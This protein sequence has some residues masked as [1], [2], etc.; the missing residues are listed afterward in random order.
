MAYYNVTVRK[1]SGEFSNQDSF[2]TEDSSLTMILSYSAYN[3]SIRALNTAGS[4]PVSSI[5][6]EQM[7]EWRGTLLLYFL[8]CYTCRLLWLALCPKSKSIVNEHWVR[9][10]DML[11]FVNAV[12]YLNF[13]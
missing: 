8:E 6:T 2:R 3:I 10:F 7:D 11:L 1:V 9:K 12:Y 4:S 5:A 13:F